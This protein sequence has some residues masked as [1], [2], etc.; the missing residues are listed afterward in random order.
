M[1]HW[2]VTKSPQDHMM[3]SS[4]FANLSLIQVGLHWMTRRVPHRHTLGYTTHI[5]GMANLSLSQVKPHQMVCRVA[6]KHIGSC[7]F[8]LVK[9]WWLYDPV[10]LCAT[11]QTIP[12][13]LTWLSDRLAIPLMCV[14][15]PSVAMCSGGVPS[16]PKAKSL[17]PREVCSRVYQAKNERQIGL[18]GW[19]VGFPDVLSSCCD[20]D[21]VW[22]RA[23]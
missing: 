13:G 2:G 22:P 3:H 20:L 12:W 19:L 17:L 5:S 6:H 18:T 1:I 23:C 14:V 16:V 8:A 7:D 4:D 9:K 11:Q 21:R 15:W 10:C